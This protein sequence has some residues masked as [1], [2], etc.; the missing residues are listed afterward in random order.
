MMKA[1]TALLGLFLLACSN[2][3][4]MQTIKSIEP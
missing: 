2:N 3:T 1:S 4:F